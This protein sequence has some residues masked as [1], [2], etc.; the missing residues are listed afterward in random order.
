MLLAV[1]NRLAPRFQDRCRR[2][3]LAFLD[4]KETTLK[5]IKNIFSP[6]KSPGDASSPSGIDY[7]AEWDEYAENWQPEGDEIAHIGDEWVGKNAGA[8]TNRTEYERLITSRYIA[9]FITAEDAVLEIG[10]GGGKTS[11]LLLQSCG[12]LQCADVSQNMIEATRKRFK[13]DKR[14]SF[15]KLNGLDFAGIPPASLDVCFIFDTLVHVE[16]RDIF[17]YLVRIP[18]LLKGKRLCVFHHGN[19]TSEL[20]FQYFLREYQGNVAG[21]RSKWPFSVMTDHIM[22]RFLDHLGYKVILNDTTSIPRDCVWVCT[23]PEA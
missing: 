11:A 21:Q 18:A 12:S 3:C 4:H 14:V 13:G 1:H 16:P 5:K 17:N 9:P 19:M 22:Q 10:I 7:G 6:R 15:V 8:A 2:A 20:G 23:A